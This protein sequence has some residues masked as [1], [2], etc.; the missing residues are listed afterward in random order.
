MID[1]IIEVANKHGKAAGINADDV[2]T[3]TKWIDRGFRMIAYSSDL[4]LIAN[5]LSDGVAKTRA[6]LAG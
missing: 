1:R 3:C 6:H 2:A 4:R 5:G